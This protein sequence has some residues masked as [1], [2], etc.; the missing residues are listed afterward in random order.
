[1]RFAG[2]K[3]TV[4]S[5]EEHPY[6]GLAR[7]SHAPGS[8]VTLAFAAEGTLESRGEGLWAA[9]RLGRS[10]LELRPGMLTLVQATIAARQT[11]TKSTRKLGQA[12]QRFDLFGQLECLDNSTDPASG[13]P[14]ME[15]RFRGQ[16]LTRL[17]AQ[18]SESSV[19]AAVRLSVL[20]TGSSE[21]V[22]RLETTG[23]QLTETLDVHVIDRATGRTVSFNTGE[24]DRVTS[25]I[26]AEL[27]EIAANLVHLSQFRWAAER[28]LAALEATDIPMDAVTL[29]FAGAGPP[30]TRAA[31]ATPHDWIFFTRRHLLDCAPIQTPTPAALRLDLYVEDR[32]EPPEPDREPTKPTGAPPAS[33]RYVSQLAWDADTDLLSSASGE[34]IDG[35]RQFHKAAQVTGAMVWAGGAVTEDRARRLVEQVVQ[36]MQPGASGVTIEVRPGPPEIPTTPGSSGAVVVSVSTRDVPPPATPPSKAEGAA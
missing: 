28:G 18:R 14:T 33:L 36:R 30:S 16:L 24:T 17:D 12:L 35:W 22:L 5:G 9:M 1:V 19:A 11:R 8:P 6:H 4:T 21:H 7:L 23:P 20:R 27:D 29:L 26:A 2:G 13:F 34:I 15:G 31:Y 10:P 32:A 3:V 25:G